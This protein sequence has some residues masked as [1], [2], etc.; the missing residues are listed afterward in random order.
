MNLAE[1]I[2]A[3]RFN[4]P[5]EVW[6]EMTKAEQWTANQKF[7]DRMIK[8]GDDIILSNPVKNIDDV[9]GAFRQ[10]LDYLIDKGF[11]LSKD[12]SRMITKKTISI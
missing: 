7:L 11:R 10:E 8:R 2:G 4:V 6:N 12:G 5:N 1:E 9:S 3:K